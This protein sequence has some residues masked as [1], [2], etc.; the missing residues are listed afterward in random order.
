MSQLV[1]STNKGLYCEAGDF[2]IDPW[3]PVDK[4]VI[5][6]GHSD[7]ARWG[8]QHYLAS[9]SSLNILR[10]RLGSEAHIQPLEFGEKIE[11]NGVTISLHPAGHLLGSSQIRLEYKGEVWVITGDYK[12]EPDRTCEPFELVKCNTFITESTFGLPIYHWKL[13]AEIF[14][15]IHDWR[16]ENMERG[17][18]CVLFAYPLGKSQRLIANVD[19][20][21]GPI[22]VH[23]SI[24]RMTNA[25]RRSGIEMPKTFHRDEINIKKEKGILVIAPPSAQGTPWL[26][27][28]G[29]ISTAFA[30][31]WM[32][33]R[34]TRRRRAIDRGFAL[35]DHAD[36]PSLLSTIE[37][38]GA[39]RVLVTHGYTEILSRY[40][41]E[42]GYDS[43]TIATHFEYEEDESEQEGL[44]E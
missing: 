23:G 11:Q 26:R 22:V 20:E 39:E 27:K 25:Y 3:R 33:I 8:S 14:S 42:R 38:T 1:R 21:L 6:H 30:S 5:T 16:L 10:E 7:H 40:L 4:A 19:P 34:G 13:Q 24:A 17:R 32:Q 18:T 37:A 41:R 36:W 2:Y 44:Q 9:R 15:D 35:S 31:G 28:F 43:S 12:T 29:S